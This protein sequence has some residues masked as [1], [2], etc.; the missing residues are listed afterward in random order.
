MEDQQA[1]LEGFPELEFIITGNAA[2][3]THMHEINDR[4]GFHVVERC[5]E[6]EK[7]L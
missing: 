2:V 5:L 7:A 1:P 3:N 4:R 6:V